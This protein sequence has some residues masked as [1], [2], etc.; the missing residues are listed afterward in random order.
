MIA[1]YNPLRMDNVT[2]RSFG[3]ALRA[4]LT[5]AQ[6]LEPLNLEIARQTLSVLTKVHKLSRTAFEMRGRAV[7]P[8]FL[9]NYSETFRAGSL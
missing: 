1:K 7:Q 4:T 9:V 8:S 6:R 2:I 5:S 3:V